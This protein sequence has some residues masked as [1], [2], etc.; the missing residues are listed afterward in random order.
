MNKLEKGTAGPIAGCIVYTGPQAATWDYTFC[1]QEILGNE[2]KLQNLRDLPTWPSSPTM[3][4]ETGEPLMD[5]D[6]AEQHAAVLF[7]VMTGAE[8]FARPLTVSEAVFLPL[9]S[10]GDERA[11]STYHLLLH[12]Y[13]FVDAGRQR[14]LGRDGQN[15]QG[16]D[17]ADKITWNQTLATCLQHPLVIPALQDFAAMSRQSVSQIKRLTQE[18][19]TSPFYKECQSTICSQWQWILHVTSTDSSWQQIEVRKPYWTLPDP[20]PG[21]AAP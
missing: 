16:A 7:G 21:G 11:L 1:G 18:L 3:D 10:G 20:M 8:T 13:F 6:K 15:G 12:G 2:P 5:Q 4:K 19:Q 9:S 17:T 14:V